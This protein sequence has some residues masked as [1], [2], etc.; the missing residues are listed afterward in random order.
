M[1][2]NGAAGEAEVLAIQDTGAMA[3]MNP[4]VVLTIKVKPAEGEEFQT[5]GQLMV[6][7]LA[8]SS[9]V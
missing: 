6:S 1:A 3:N 5:A 4:I 2:K 7:R 9:S 8:V